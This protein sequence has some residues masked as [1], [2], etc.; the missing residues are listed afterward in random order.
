M[1]NTV[2][3]PDLP[4]ED[5]RII[6]G[7]LNSFWRSVYEDNEIIRD[8]CFGSGEVAAQT[9]L[10]FLEMINS[11]S[12]QDIPVFHRE[13]WLPIVLKRSEQNT[14][15][16]IVSGQTPALV[17]GP[18]PEDTAYDAYRVYAV[19]DSAYRAGSVTY[20]LNTTNPLAGGVERISNQIV[21][22]T[23]TLLKD[24][25]YAL[26]GN[27]IVFTTEADPFASDEFPRRKTDND[28]EIL[29]W[30]TDALFDW[31]FIYDNYGYAV[32]LDGVSSQQYKNAVNSLWDLRYSGN[33]L[34]T[35]RTS[36]GE[37][38][39]VPAA[40]NDGE[41]IEAIYTE[42]DDTLTLVTDKEVYNYPAGSELSEGV[43]V[44][45]TVNKGTFLTQTVRLYARLNPDK[46]FASNGTTLS[47]FVTRVPTLFL[48]KGIIGNYGGNAGL[49]ASWGDADLTFEGIDSNG[50]NQ[51]RFPVNGSEEN[52]ELFWQNTWD[53][54]AASATDLSTI[55]ADYIFDPGPYT[56][57]GVTAGTINPM[58]YL[59]R[60]FLR[61]NVGVLLVDFT[62][63]PGHIRSLDI[64]SRLNQLIAAHSLLLIVGEQSVTDPAYQL[65][66]DA[67]ESLD[68]PFGK[69]LTDAY[70]TFKEGGL[71]FTWVKV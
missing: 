46:F 47:D 1:A 70:T 44:G 11:M 13:R 62:T 69:A 50:N 4:I 31:T 24:I 52:V 10:N 16:G 18:Q 32:A 39:G 56:E 64:L 21:A 7:S 61:D 20:T 49:S 2:P 34:S 8:Y 68:T 58:E 60:T 59:M 30:A 17:I 5:G 65:D 28:E 66:E 37:M 9:Y 6:F 27:S 43:S 42:Y 40:R 23:V 35:L 48:P 54:A 51:Y 26:E 3:L 22:P 29:I 41:V 67:F 19:G 25:D 55:F 36:I 33:N 71:T 45:A 15:T 14:G 57:I 63:L 53:R 38:T 12:R